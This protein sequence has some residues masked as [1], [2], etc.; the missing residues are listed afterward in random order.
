MFTNICVYV[1]IHAHKCICSHMYTL[2]QTL[3]GITHMF[4]TST[5]MARKKTKSIHIH[6]GA[7]SMNQ[8]GTMWVGKCGIVKGQNKE[9]VYMETGLCVNRAE[10]THH[11]P[12]P[13]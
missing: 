4:L 6:I 5:C 2:K 12:L 3:R 7:P 13:T 1:G 11:S 10:L 9:G 8:G